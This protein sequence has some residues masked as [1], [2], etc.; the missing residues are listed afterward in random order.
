MPATLDKVENYGAGDGRGPHTRTAQLLLSLVLPIECAPLG[1]GLPG[2]LAG[3]G[4]KLYAS[5]DLPVAPRVLFP[6]VVV[7]SLVCTDQVP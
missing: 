6:F 4:C 5:Q 1:P 7:S 3:R 2:I